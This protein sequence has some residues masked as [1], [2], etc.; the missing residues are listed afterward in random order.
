MDEVKRRLLQLTDVRF[1]Y[2]GKDQDTIRSVRLSFKT[3]EFVAILGPNGAGK[4]TLARLMIGILRPTGGK[5]S[6]DDL[7]LSRFTVAQIS[8]WIGFLFQNPN[9]QLFEDRAWDEVMTG[10]K[11]MELSE[12]EK[13]QR[14]EEVLASCGLT[15]LKEQPPE[16]LSIGEK[17]R[18]AVASVLAM[19][20]DFLIL[21]EP[22]TGQ[23][24]SHLHPL[25]TLIDKLNREN[26]GIIMI[27]HD[28]GLAA[29][30]AS[31]VVVL[32][33]GQVLFDGSNEELFR[34]AA[35]LERSHLEAPSLL[36]LSRRL[37]SFGIE[38]SF[39]SQ[40]L[41]EQILRRKSCRE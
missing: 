37:E 11:S 36:T 1:R 41:V 40:D 30:Y 39:R 21:D 9:H 3:D 6:L 13:E 28:V 22:T 26:K 25:M 35:L 17:K 5:V 16:N 34:D 23:T 32:A 31:R 18:L 8:H 33:E 27:T 10:M 29:R 20:T 4:T 14:T 12:A 15:K 2:Y 7:D 38:P 24:W 19:G